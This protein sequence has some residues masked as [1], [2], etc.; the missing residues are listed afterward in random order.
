MKWPH[1]HKQTN[2]NL[3]NIS[4]SPLW[5]NRDGITHLMKSSTHTRPSDTVQV[6]DH[7]PQLLPLTLCLYVKKKKTL[8]VYDEISHSIPQCDFSSSRQTPNCDGCYPR[9]IQSNP[10]MKT[11]IYIFSLGFGSS[12][13]FSPQSGRG[14]TLTHIYLF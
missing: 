2:H 1:T 11:N 14:L 8:Y 10:K 3:N 13:Y 4:I 12:N 7:V 5:R 6:F 9:C